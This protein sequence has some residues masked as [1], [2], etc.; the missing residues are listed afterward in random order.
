MNNIKK[1]KD[2]EK[3]AENFLSKKGYKILERNYLKRQGEIDIIA[4]DSKYKEI[5]FI[6]VKTRKNSEYGYP[7]EFVTKKKIEKI[8]ST[9]YIWLKKHKKI[10]DFWRI[11]IIAIELNYN[12][13]KIEHLEN[14]TQSFSS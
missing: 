6:E 5:V 3:M 1:G 8:S 13:P 14:I 9:A 7:E 10:D 2:G 4:F 12:P 11:D